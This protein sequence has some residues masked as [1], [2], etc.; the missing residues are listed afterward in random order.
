[1]AQSPD[2]LIDVRVVAGEAFGIQSAIGTQTPVWLQDWRVFSG[3]SAEIEINS[4]FNVAAYVFEGTVCF[5]ADKTAAEQ[6][7]LAVMGPG[8]TLQM[9]ASPGNGAGRFLLLAGEPLHEP[10]VRYGPFV[11]NTQE[12]LVRAVEDYQTGRMG[13]VSRG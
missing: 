10:V 9:H 7:H 13:R 5:G 1:M 3:A 11:M 8:M 12:E 6:G 2:G 4:G